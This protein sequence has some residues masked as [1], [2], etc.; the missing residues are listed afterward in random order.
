MIKRKKLKSE[1]YKGKTIRFKSIRIAGGASA[2]KATCGF[3]S[4]TGNTKRRAF[5]KIKRKL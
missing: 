4:A 3:T 5:N 2:V 1:K